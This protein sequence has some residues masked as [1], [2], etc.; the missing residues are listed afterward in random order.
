M[1]VSSSV[2]AEISSLTTT[3]SVQRIAGSNRYGTTAEV[4]QYYST[5]PDTVYLASGEEFPDAL[6]IAALAGRQEHPLLLTRQGSLP[7]ATKKAL[8]RLRPGRIVVVG[9][10]TAVSQDVA[11][12]VR[13][14]TTSGRVSRWAGANRY[15]TA[16]KIARNSPASSGIWVAPGQDFPD[17]LVGAA[18]AAHEG[19]PLVL[20]RS[21]SAPSSTQDVVRDG[22]ASSMVVLGGTSVVSAP[23][24]DRLRSLLR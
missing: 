18:R 11:Q 13:G 6:S 17:A 3:G 12:A 9:G 7:L 5:R 22:S 21:A 1:R 16:A 10:T 14:L 15:G 4:A 2:L 19:H 20:T 23:T 8:T 24:F